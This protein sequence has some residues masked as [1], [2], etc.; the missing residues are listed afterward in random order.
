MWA[1]LT[2]VVL[3]VRMLA[4]IAAILCV[5]G[6]IVVA[7]RSSLNNGFLWPAV[8]SGVALLVST[9]LYSY[10]RPRHPRHNGWIP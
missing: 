3:V 8:I 7:V 6:W 2:T 10:L 9:Y 5:I 1:V 4:T